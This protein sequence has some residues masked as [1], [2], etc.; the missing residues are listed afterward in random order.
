MR[1][2]PHGQEHGEEG[3][4]AGSALLE[5]NA[6]RNR[7]AVAA[8]ELERDEDDG[9]EAETKEAAPDFRVVPGVD[10]AAPLQGE[11]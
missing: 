8:V 11:K 9:D 1:V 3:A 6:G 7:G 10:G 5:E 2:E 4:S